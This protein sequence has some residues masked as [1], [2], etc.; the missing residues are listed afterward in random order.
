[1]PHPMTRRARRAITTMAAVA[2]IATTL[3]GCS[4]A[5]EAAPGSTADGTAAAEIAQPAG[6]ETVPAPGPAIDVSTLAGATVYWI[7]ITSQAPVFSIEQAAATEAFAAAGVKLQLCDGEA[8]P[9]SVAKCTTQAVSA[10]AAGIIATSIPPEFAQQ[11]FGAAVTAGVPVLFVNTKDATTPTEWGD[12]AAALPA[13]FTVQAKVNTDLII[14]DSKKA[15]HVLVIGVT[16][17]SVTTS[18]YESITAQYASDCPDCVV[19]SVEVGSTTLSNLSSQVSAALVKDPA[20]SYVQVEF[21]SFAAPVVQ[22]IRQ[23]NKSSSIKVVS[24][25]GQLD[26]MKR[27]ADGS[28]FADTTYSL[29]ALGWNEADVM[30]RMMLGVDPAIDGHKTPIKTYTSANISSA[31]L[32]E[33]AWKSG[34]WS[35]DDDFRS[36]YTMLWGAS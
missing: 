31:D 10:G 28:G 23:L 34:E 15:A 18:V 25:L 4:A 9:A 6:Y 17:S 20:I 14:A 29:A 11:S 12:L 13:N 19:S 7:P 2:A 35:S 32:T 21:D 24:M 36:M 33:A 1:M 27:I 16:D 22:A 8:N 3:A 26:G 5:G 30:L